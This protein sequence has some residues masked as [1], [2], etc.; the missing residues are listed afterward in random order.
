MIKR[1]VL[2]FFGVLLA[3]AALLF[4]VQALFSHSYTGF[5]L[6]SDYDHSVKDLDVGK[7][8][9]SVSLG[10]YKLVENRIR[11]NSVLENYLDSSQTIYLNFKLIKGDIVISDGTK[12]VILSSNSNDKFIFDFPIPSETSGIVNLNIVFSNGQYSKE[13][14]IR[15][16]NLPEANSRI[17][18]NIIQNGDNGRIF[19]GVLV[20][21]AIISVLFLTSKLYHKRNAVNY[22]K[23]NF[24]SRFIALD[25]G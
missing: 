15:D 12:E 11:V 5:V 24:N 25:F 6:E 23:K 4:L 8:D 19:F 1:R 14:N 16:I 2:R 10:S 21:V 22:F 17:T 13:A 9:F 3:F 20:V 18:G 7:S